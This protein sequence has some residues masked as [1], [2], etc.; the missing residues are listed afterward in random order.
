MHKKEISLLVFSPFY[1]PRIG[2]LESHADEFNKHIAQKGVTITTFTARLPKSAPQYEKKYDNKVEIVRYPAFYI[3]PN[4]PLPQFWRPLFWRLL[5]ALSHK[6]YDIVI[7]RLRFFI[8]SFAGLLF[9]KWTHTPLMHIEHATQVHLNSAFKNIL[10]HFYDYALGRL[11][12]VFADCLVANAKKTAQFCRHIYK[13][14]RCEVI[15]RGVEIEAIATYP[16]ATNLREKYHNK[17]II[18]FVGRLIDGKGVADL[19]AAVS[20][21][22]RDFIVFIVGD[23][24]QRNNL[25]KIT[26]AHK[27]QKRIIFCGYKK[28]SEVIGI[29]KISDIIVSPSYTEG[30]PTALIE[31][32]L[33]K[34]AIVATNVG[35]TAEIIDGINDGILIQPKN[36]TQLRKKIIYL[37]NNPQVRTKYGTHAYEKA[38]KTFTW[39][40]ATDQYMTLFA[41]LIAKKEKNH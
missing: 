28:Q 34:K 12:F 40:R 24:P 1:P 37:I 35:G 26:A 38:K 16:S 15:Y 41:D 4:Y 30:L 25:E 36:I 18:T 31:A 8:S 27:M 9:A 5:F 20:E 17:I 2:G 32:A 10:A 29:M 13:K 39:Q 22:E 23:G 11:S 7:T 21:I 6:Q 14:A 33:C 3:I 19:I